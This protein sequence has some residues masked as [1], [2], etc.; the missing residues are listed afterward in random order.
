[1]QEVQ[2]G[3]Q[4]DIRKGEEM[5]SLWYVSCG[6]GSGKFI[7]SRFKDT[8][9]ATAALTTKLSCLDQ[10]WQILGMMRCTCVHSASST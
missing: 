9:T 7:H 6:S 4:P 10:E 8:L 3:V 5:Q 1:M 2:Q